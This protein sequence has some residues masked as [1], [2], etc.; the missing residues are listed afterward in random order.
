MAVSVEWPLRKLDWSFW[1]KVVGYQIGNQLLGNNLLHDI[2][3]DNGVSSPRA[4][5]WALTP[6]TS[7][8]CPVSRSRAEK[9]FAHF[10]D[11]CT[12]YYVTFT[13]YH[14]SLTT[15]EQYRLVK[16]APESAFWSHYRA[17][18]GALADWTR[19][20]Q[21]IDLSGDPSSVLLH[22][23]RTLTLEPHTACRKGGWGLAKIN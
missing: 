15:S 4:L 14:W 3:R 21:I 17:S 6:L 7:K 12:Y 19:P 18:D 11:T 20:M 1:H 16:I 5:S 23:T 13:W 9:N 22:L 2:G 10:V 8:N